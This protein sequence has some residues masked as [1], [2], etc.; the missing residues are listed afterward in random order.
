M[1]NGTREEWAKGCECTELEVCIP[2][3]DERAG[4]TI[5]EE[6]S[7]ILRWVLVEKSGC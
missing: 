1:I 6:I 5:T 3:T 2:V 7:I 4:R